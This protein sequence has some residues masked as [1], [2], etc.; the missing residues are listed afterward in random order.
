[1]DYNVLLT[2]AASRQLDA[3]PTPVALRVAAALAGLAQDPRPHGCRKLKIETG[4]AWRVRVGDHRVL[5]HIDDRAQ[6]VRVFAIRHRRD[7]YRSR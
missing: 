1:M 5:Y 7:A 2:K 4:E 6:E 3:L